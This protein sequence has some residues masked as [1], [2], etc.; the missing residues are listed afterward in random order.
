MPGYSSKTGWRDADLQAAERLAWAV[1]KKVSHAT[2]DGA[3][4]SDKEVLMEARQNLL[5]K[6]KAASLI[7]SFHQQGAETVRIKSLLAGATLAV[8]PAG[9]E[10]N[11][12]YDSSIL[13]WAL[14]QPTDNSTA[15]A[16]A[17]LKRRLDTLYNPDHDKIYARLEQIP[18][19]ECHFYFWRN[20]RGGRVHHL[21]TPF[22]NQ[23]RMSLLVQ[24]KIDSAVAE[25]DTINGQAVE[26]LFQTIPDMLHYYITEAREIITQ[27]EAKKLISQAKK[28]C[29]S[30]KID[31]Q[32]IKEALTE[33]RLLYPSKPKK[34]G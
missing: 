34:R 4:Y 5:G 8:T 10:Q 18:V 13:I 25:M 23:R 11:P 1:H 30:G 29:K 21:P 32:N 26:H 24:R 17:E 20:F 14:A 19:D 9:V 33:L 27:P 31:R 15:R 28:L 22:D 6:K 16:G 2:R 12:G 3:G 7:E